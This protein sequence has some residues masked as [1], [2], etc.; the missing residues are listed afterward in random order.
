MKAET[1]NAMSQPSYPT[2]GFASMDTATVKRIASMG[3]KSC[4]QRGTGAR[5]DQSG[6]TDCGAE[7]WPQKR[8]GEARAEGAGGVMDKFMTKR[9]TEMINRHIEILSELR[10]V[11]APCGRDM[12]E[13]DEQGLKV[14]IV[15]DHLDNA[16]G[17]YIDADAIAD[18]YQEYV[19]CFQRLDAET[20]SF[21][22][23]RINLADLIAL[24][25][26]AQ[27]TSADLVDA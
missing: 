21:V 1:K 24:A 4:H 20:K 23:A 3:G 6:S 16:C 2:R 13:P 8:A 19:L 10:K 5:V 27:P 9:H 15:G 12:H 17:N 25:R 18:G 11:T 26:M 14:R 22:R 7:R